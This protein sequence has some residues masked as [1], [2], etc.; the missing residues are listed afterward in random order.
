[1]CGCAHTQAGR[2]DAKAGHDGL[3][4]SRRCNRWGRRAPA[5]GPS[6]QGS[7][8]R[9]HVTPGADGSLPAWPSLRRS[10]PWVRRRRLGNLLGTLVLSCWVAAISEP[11]SGLVHTSD[12]HETVVVAVDNPQHP[13]VRWDDTVH[14]SKGEQVRVICPQCGEERL[15][16]AKMVR[17]QV[18]RGQFTA[19]CRADATR[20]ARAALPEPRH[21][22]V[23]WGSITTTTPSTVAVTCPICAKAR[24]VVASS[25]RS[26]LRTGKF[27]G[28]C[29]ADREVGKPRSQIRPEHSLVDWSDI[30]VVPEGGK[31]GARRAM[32]RVACPVCR[33]SR[34]STPPISRDSLSGASFGPNA[35]ITE[36]GSSRIAR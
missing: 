35:D 14:S 26:Q 33:P 19:L 11:N 30:Q 1:V 36:L 32:V 31:A 18:S 22:A 17:H 16:S 34:P 29:V 13:N 27:T 6:R 8:R 4:C 24:A 10:P 3:R 12:L 20:L 5:G 25:V 9:G 21:S 7:H 23:D 2:F 15:A 28:R